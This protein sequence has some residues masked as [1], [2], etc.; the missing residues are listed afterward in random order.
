MVSNF[1]SDQVLL[2]GTSIWKDKIGQKVADER[3]TL[4]LKPK[5]PRIV[6]GECITSDGFLS[7]DFDL[8]KEGVLESFFLSLYVANKTG[9]APA[10]TRG[11]N[12]VIEPGDTPLEEMIA[13]IE[14][15]I[16]VGRF[17][18]GNPNANG[19]FSGVAKNSFMIEDGKI[20]DAISETMI[21]GNL[22]DLLHHIVSISKETLVDGSSVL[23]YMGFDNV[24]ISGK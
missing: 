13:G 12:L 21:N 7:Q 2:D 4:S 1:V 10:K 20:T 23:P 11:F 22:A 15:G 5:D 9:Q 6:C 3:L 24:V 8:I 17:S 18:G 14:K 19:E 16:I